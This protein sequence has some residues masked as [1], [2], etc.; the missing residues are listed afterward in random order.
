MKIATITLTDKAIEDRDYRD[1]FAIEIDGERV[2]EVWDG[3]PEDN[4]LVRNFSSIYSIPKLLQSAYDA[5]KA[6]EGLIF[7]KRKVDE[8]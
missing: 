6:G 7:E 2:F 1:I 5:G 4:T 3:E 8:F